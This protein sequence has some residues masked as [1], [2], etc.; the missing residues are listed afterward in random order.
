[1]LLFKPMRTHT[2]AWITALILIVALVVGARYYTYIVKRDFLIEASTI[3]DSS[4]EACFT[5]DCD[6]EDPEC[7]LTPYKKVEIVA[8]EAPECLEEHRCESFTCE[9]WNHAPLP[10]VQM[11]P[12]KK[13]SDAR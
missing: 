7:D 9:G 6:T 12:S 2:T 5:A 13:E 1:M 8:N 4:T 10:I 11:R 3:C